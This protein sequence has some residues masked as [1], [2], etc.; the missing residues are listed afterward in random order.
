MFVT[1][2]GRQELVEKHTG[3]QWRAYN[4][5]NLEL[6]AARNLIPLPRFPQ[7]ESR[8]GESSPHA[9]ARAAPA[10]TA[11]TAQ[12]AAPPARGASPPLRDPPIVLS[13]CV[14]SRCSALSEGDCA[15]GKELR[16]AATSALTFTTFS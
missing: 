10:K 15:R 1:V 13:R 7:G 3:K 2:I 14:T 9:A 6:P 5:R 11:G 16:M 12:A 4:R 8:G